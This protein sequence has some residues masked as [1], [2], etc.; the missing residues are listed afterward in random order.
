MIPVTPLPEPDD[1]DSKVRQ[2]G[3]SAIAE[4]TGNPPT[5][6]RSGPKREKIAETPAGIPPGELP[7]FWRECLPDLLTGYDRI[8]AYACVYIER[9]TG[10]GTVDHFVAKSGVVLEA[11]DWDNYRLACSLMNARKNDVPHVLDPFAIGSDWFRIELVSLDVVPNPEQPAQIR[12]QVQATIDQ[13]RLNDAECVQLREQYLGDYAH[14]DISSAYLR[15]RA[16]FLAMEL[17]RQG[18]P[19]RRARP[20]RP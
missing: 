5:I 13:L 9:V 12:D 16:P 10:A 8:C 4:L 19:P 17:D 14:E 6:K 7:P 3:L 15:R 2:P 20:S 18:W 1:F 11:Y